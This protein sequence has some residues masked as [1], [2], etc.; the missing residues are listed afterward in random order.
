MIGSKEN[1]MNITDERE[2]SR[3]KA[4]IRRAHTLTRMK[5]KDYNEEGKTK[6]YQ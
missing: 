3:K 5:K 6:C 1:C 4:N 2:R